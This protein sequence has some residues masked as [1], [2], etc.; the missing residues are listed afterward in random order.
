MPPP[1]SRRN[2]PRIALAPRQLVRIH[3]GFAPRDAH[4]T[5]FAGTHLNHVRLKTARMLLWRVDAGGVISIDVRG[6]FGSASY[7]ARI[8]VH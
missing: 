8:T 1:Q 6:R 4:L 3:L 5:R 2:L 7:L